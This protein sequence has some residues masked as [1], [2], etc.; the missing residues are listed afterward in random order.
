MEMM[1]AQKVV[2]RRRLG[3]CFTTGIIAA[4]AL[5]SVLFLGGALFSAKWMSNPAGTPW[6]RTD[7]AVSK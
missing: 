2:E 4:T 6:I 1:S 3:F 5:A 7:Q